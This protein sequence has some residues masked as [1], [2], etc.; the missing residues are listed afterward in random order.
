[1]RI[2]ALTS[3]GSARKSGISVVGGMF[4]DVVVGIEYGIG[5][6]EIK[7]FCNHETTIEEPW[8]IQRERNID[9]G[10]PILIHAHT[11]TRTSKPPHQPATTM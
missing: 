4:L 9:Y 5:E 11:R 8:E 7:D 1:M 2:R 10:W 6:G 3:E